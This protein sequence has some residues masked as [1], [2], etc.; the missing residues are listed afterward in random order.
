MLR[1]PEAPTYDGFKRLFSAAPVT[2][3]PPQ[4][5]PGLPTARAVAGGRAAG[6][7]RDSR[8]ALAYEAAG[9]LATG[10][11]T[12]SAAATLWSACRSLSERERRTHDEVVRRML[13]DGFR[14]L[15]RVRP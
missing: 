15:R 9:W 7:A 4:R 13:Q 2:A 11:I 10:W 3:T 6:S 1:Q 14:L 12:K 5:P 8:R